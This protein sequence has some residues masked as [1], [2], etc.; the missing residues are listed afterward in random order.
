M[1]GEVGEGG[2]FRGFGKYI[3]IAGL[4]KGAGNFTEK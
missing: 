2:D 1:G 3:A 4:L